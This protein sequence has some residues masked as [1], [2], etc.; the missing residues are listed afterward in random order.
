MS[1]IGRKPLNIKDLSVRLKNESTVDL[2]LKDR[3]LSFSLPQG[4]SFELEDD[5]LTICAKNLSQY[6][7][8]IGLQRSL[9]DNFLSGTKNA[10]QK[11][12]N[13]GGVGFRAS[14]VDNFL[15]LNI[16]FS[17]I[18]K[19]LIPEDLQV[20][21]VNQTSFIVSGS[22]KCALGTFVSRVKNIRKVEPYKARGISLEDDFILR[23]SGKSKK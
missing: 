7:S 1:R 16:G 5:F 11:V 20:K 21:I 9:L 12:V 17:H 3:V 22:D 4:L 8:V 14:V 18:V 15:T 10:F 23:K 19:F 13:L 6:S 2:Q